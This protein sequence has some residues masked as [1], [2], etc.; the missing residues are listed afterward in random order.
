M[1]DRHSED[2][3]VVGSPARMMEGNGHGHAP[4]RIVNRYGPALVDIRLPVPELR[5]W[6]GAPGIRVRGLRLVTTLALT[7]GYRLGALESIAEGLSGESRCGHAD[8]LPLAAEILATP[9]GPVVE[10]GVGPSGMYVNELV[11]GTEDEGTLRGLLD[12]SFVRHARGSRL[13]DDY[14]AAWLAVPDQQGHTH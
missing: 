4:A 11:M 9:L 10:F 6:I 13:P 7:E 2:K 14:L 1:D 8:N 5:L 3:P 12:R